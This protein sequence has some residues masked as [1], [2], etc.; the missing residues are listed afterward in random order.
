MSALFR[1]A[2]VIPGYTLLV[3]GNYCWL[4]NLPMM[5]RAPSIF[6]CTFAT[7]LVAAAVVTGWQ[8]NRRETSSEEVQ[9]VLHVQQESHRLHHRIT[10][11][12][13]RAN[14]QA[15]LTGQRQA[16]HD[17]NGNASLQ[18]H[19]E[20]QAWLDALSLT[21][22]VGLL[23]EMERSARFHDLMHKLYFHYGS[24][25]HDGALRR[26]GG[27]PPTL[28]ATD[29]LK[30]AFLSDCIQG[31]GKSS[32]AEAWAYFVRGTTEKG[33]NPI[34]DAGEADRIPYEVFKSWAALDA[35]GAFATFRGIPI[36]DL[37]WGARGY[38]EGL[39]A[40]ADFRSVASDWENLSGSRR[41]VLN[42]LGPVENET[43]HFKLSLTLA[44]K[45][46]DR[47]VEA[48]SVWWLSQ[49]KSGKSDA[50]VS[51]EQIEKHKAYWIGHLIGNWAGHWDYESENN[52]TGAIQWIL[53]NPRYLQC[54]EFQNIA[55]PA[56]A[57]YRP[58]E[59]LDLIRRVESTWRRFGIL[60][61]L[62]R[63]PTTAGD[64]IGK[65][66][67]PSAILSPDTVEPELATFGLA[68]DELKHVQDTIA[69]R[70]KFDAEHP[71]P[72]SS[73]W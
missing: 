17:S 48:A 30:L 26:L 56:I 18:Y 32:P 28:R 23:D 38:M 47:D 44:T 7:I 65:R 11:S 61:D 1:I 46:M 70:R 49:D 24:L 19:K 43:Q 62:L 15:V 52:P 42:L 39:P 50:V 2:R 64:G 45:W 58:T 20:T 68:A 8:R 57:R 60:V 9:G 12:E 69:E 16:P 66:R 37:I 41:D 54:L 71:A 73:T 40:N 25:D 35:S 31:W 33:D 51:A 36:E 3:C 53:K 29:S 5:A 55:L 10:S 63:S 67:L 72:L 34:R 6:R 21:D 4:E 22:C 13:A 27:D 14:L 59:A